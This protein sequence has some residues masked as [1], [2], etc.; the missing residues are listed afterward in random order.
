MAQNTLWF[1]DVVSNGHVTHVWTTSTHTHT[2]THMLNHSKTDIEKCNSITNVIEEIK[3]IFSQATS[4]KALRPP[5][6]WRTTGWEPLIYTNQPQTRFLLCQLY[7]QLA[8]E[9]MFWP[10]IFWRLD[11]STW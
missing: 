6:G 3:L 10:G 4:G 11:V 5:M 7:I 8:F 1:L 2:Q 9:S